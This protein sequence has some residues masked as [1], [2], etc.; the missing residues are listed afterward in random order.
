MKNIAIM[1]MLSL[2]L[3]ATAQ[4]NKNVTKETKTTTVTVDD[5]DE[6]KKVVKTEKTDATQ[7]IE[8][9]DAKSKKLNKDVKPTPVQVN[10]TT[11]ISGDG[12]PAQQVERTSYYEMNGRKF[13]FV[14]DKTGYRIFTP[15]NTDYAVLRRTSNNNYIYRTGNRTSIA[16][17]DANG[18]LVVETYDD[19]TDGVTVETYTVVKQ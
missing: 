6:K 8:L 1:I 9:K 18:N 7:N 3:T 5:G 15:D 14:T 17:F 2:G 13:R 4:V 12:I 19:K 10:S 16:Y 11:T